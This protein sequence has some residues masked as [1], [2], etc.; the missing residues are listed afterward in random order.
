[1]SFAVLGG[2][3]AQGFGAGLQEKN[4]M[5]PTTAALA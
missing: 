5:T 1:M 2:F 3:A 4:I